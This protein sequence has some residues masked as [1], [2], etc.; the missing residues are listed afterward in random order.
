MVFRRRREWIALASA[1]LSAGSLGCSGTGD[2]GTGDPRSEPR[3]D[4]YGDGARLSEINGDATWYDENDV[5]SVSCKKPADR[6]VYLTGQ[7]IVALDRYDETGEG[8]TGNIYVQ[9]ARAP[10]EVAQPYSGMT[11]FGPAFT[12]PNLRLFEGDVVDTFGTFLEF[13][14]PT[15]GPFGNCKTLPEVTGTMSF[16]FEGAL[17]E[18]HLLVPGDGGNARWEPLK[19]YQAARPWMGMLVKIE[20]VTAARAPFESN[21]R[22]S[23]DLDVGGGILQS[24]IPRISNEL[25]DIKTRGPEIVQG[26]QFRSVTGVLTYFYGFKIA[27]R[28]PDDFE[29]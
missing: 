3:A 24:D 4:L 6:R 20:N 29:L 9:D 22:Y 10:G 14:G 17:A 2:G 18:P 15:S 13:L 12:P 1:A 8:A 28:S 27:P 16:R 21:G 7:V 26:T 19:S 5:G 25:Y 11:V 23:V